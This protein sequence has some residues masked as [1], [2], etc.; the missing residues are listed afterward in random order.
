MF[1]R[2]I[3]KTNWDRTQELLFRQ[4][5]FQD[6]VV[7]S[8]IICHGNTAAAV[9]F[10]TSLNLGYSDHLFNINPGESLFDIVKSDYG[11]VATAMKRKIRWF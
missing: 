10:L 11:G 5:C 3:V 9:I 7:R 8:T 2:W 4:D 6:L 1:S